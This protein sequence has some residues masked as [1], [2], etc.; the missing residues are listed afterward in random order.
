MTT[1][2]GPWN[3]EFT[4]CLYAKLRTRA[5]VGGPRM[6]SQMPMYFE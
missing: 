3:A 1:A 4:L 2:R 6:M 5:A